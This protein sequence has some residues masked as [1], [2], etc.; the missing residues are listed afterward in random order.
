MSIWIL[1][2]SVTAFAL[3]CVTSYIVGKKMERGRLAKRQA[4]LSDEYAKVQVDRAD[5]RDELIDR[6]RKDGL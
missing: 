1:I 2:G 6:L 5:T 3:A 4:K